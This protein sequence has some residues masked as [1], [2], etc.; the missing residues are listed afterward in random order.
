MDSPE[1]WRWIWLVATALFLAGELATA[2]TFFLVC[3]AVGAALAALL[4]F[5]GVAVPLEWLAFVAGSAGAFAAFFPLRQRLDRRL[6]QTGIGAG[7]LIGEVAVVV[8]ALPPGAVGLVRVT[9]EEW[10]AESADGAA[11]DE[12]DRVRILEVRGTRVIVGPAE[13]Q[14]TFKPW[15]MP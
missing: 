15:E 11:F 4:A 13:Q 6:P 1:T 2:G 9:G 14:P 10:R 7:R 8:R 5:L 3:F 12:G